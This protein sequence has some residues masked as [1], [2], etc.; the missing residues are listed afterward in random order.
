MELPLAPR[1]RRSAPGCRMVSRKGRRYRCGK[2]LAAWTY[3][4]V[5]SQWTAS[6][7]LCHSHSPF[8]ARSL[9]LDTS[10]PAY[11]RSAWRLLKTM[12]LN[13]HKP[14]TQTTTGTVQHSILVPF[15]TVHN[16]C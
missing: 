9:E 4:L 11:G 2:L 14:G 15:P 16:M 8:Q 5:T 7:Q 3:L 13:L 12:L 6:L 1:L 10:S